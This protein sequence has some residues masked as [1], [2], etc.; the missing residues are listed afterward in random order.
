MTTSQVQKAAC[1]LPVQEGRAMA[2]TASER[3]PFST[4]PTVDLS[5]VAARIA[6]T[7]QLFDDLSAAGA[8]AVRREEVLSRITEFYEPVVSQLARRYRRRGAD[9]DELRQVGFVGLM[10]AVNNY[11]VARGDL[12]PYAVATILGEIKR[13][14][15]DR[16]WAI[17]P[18]RRVQ[19]LEM[20][21]TASQSDLAQSTRHTPTVD[22]LADHMGEDRHEV[23][24]AVGARSLFNLLSTDAPSAEGDTTTLGDG[25]GADES[26][27]GRA[28]ASAT[29]RSALARSTLSERDRQVLALRFFEDMT[30]REIACVIGTTQMQV[31]R[32]LK[33][34]LADLRQAIGPMSA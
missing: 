32:I 2:V 6:Y 29:I 13:H 33:R 21:I 23:A 26:G 20:R 3:T 25:L 27:F 15:R 14:F 34:A 19:E 1:A 5:D 22:E 11:D 30:Q 24:V 4:T 7:H 17:R 9:D 28:E 12:M 18:T 10:K 16:C 31:S 8:D